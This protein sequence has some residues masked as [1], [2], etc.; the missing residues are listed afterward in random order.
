LKTTESGVATFE[1]TLL[2]RGP[3]G[4]ENFVLPEGVQVMNLGNMAGMLEDALGGGGD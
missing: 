2:Q 4:A 1:A 3:Q